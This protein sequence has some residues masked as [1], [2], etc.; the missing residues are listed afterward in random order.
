VARNYACD[1]VSNSFFAKNLINCFKL[2]I[3]LSCSTVM[4]IRCDQ[5]ILIR[6]AVDNFVL[7]VT[8]SFLPRTQNVINVFNQNMAA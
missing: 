2:F 1:N 5:E 6:K 3:R 4:I 7:A 8:P